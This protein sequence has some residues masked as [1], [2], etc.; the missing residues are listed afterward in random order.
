L[1]LKRSWSARISFQITEL[2]LLTRI[3]ITD[4]IIIIAADVV[5]SIPLDFLLPIQV[6]I[7]SLL[8]TANP[9]QPECVISG[10]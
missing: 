9:S 8:S 10:Y 7:P 3:V 4:T 6:L 2:C 5:S 1:I